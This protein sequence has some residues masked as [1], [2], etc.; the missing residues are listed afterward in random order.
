MLYN[1]YEDFFKN[2]TDIKVYKVKF[3]TKGQN[4]SLILDEDISIEKK[5]LFNFMNL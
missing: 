5:L 3:I 1:E 2:I 4:F